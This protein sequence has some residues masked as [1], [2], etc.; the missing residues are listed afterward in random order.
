MIEFSRQ[1][2]DQETR[3]VTARC[4]KWK[5][6]SRSTVVE[7]QHAF[8]QEMVRSRGREE[9]Q[10]NI[11]NHEQEQQSGQLTHVLS[12]RSSNPVVR[13]RSEVQCIAH[14]SRS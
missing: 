5:E 3:A 11:R 6:S 9:Q 13:Q 1:I 12:H 10:V 8:Q 2:C 14:A 7:R 4:V